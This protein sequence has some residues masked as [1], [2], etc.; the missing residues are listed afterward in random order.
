[1]ND[2]L[3]LT[4][5]LCGVSEKKNTSFFTN[6]ACLCEIHIYLYG[7]EYSIFRNRVIKMKYSVCITIC[8]SVSCNRVQ[9]ILYGIYVYIIVHKLGHKTSGRY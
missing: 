6:V 1:M 4:P 8:I 7:K 2:K 9:N 3:Y 5:K